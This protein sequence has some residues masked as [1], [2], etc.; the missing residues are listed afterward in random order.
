VQ[1]INSPCKA[2]TIAEIAGESPLTSGNV[3]SKTAT[4]RMALPALRIIDVS[5]E[6]VELLVGVAFCHR[7][8]RHNKLPP[9]RLPLVIIAVGE[10]SSRCPNRAQSE[11]DQTPELSGASATN[12]L[13]CAYHQR[14]E[15]RN[16]GTI[17]K[18]D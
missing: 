5:L 4:H 16:V 10:A 13:E 12:A 6:R 15:Q 1:T 8:A 7:N 9:P 17:L 11:Q 18:L 3:L 14:P 2:R